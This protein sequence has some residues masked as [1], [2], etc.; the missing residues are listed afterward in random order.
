MVL[1]LVQLE[2]IAPGWWEQLAELAE[3]LGT[4]RATLNRSL[5][6]LQT[7]GLIRYTALSNRSGTWIWWVARHQGDAPRPE[8]EPAWVVR[9]SSRKMLSRIPLTRR[10]EWAEQRSI[11]KGT[12]TSFLYGYQRL[13]R[14]RWELV[15]TPLDAPAADR[16]E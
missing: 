4:D 16:N 1:V 3:L 13:L 12:M 15:S 11:P 7:R 14:N 9:D 5:R 10:W 2:Q 6:H 8:D